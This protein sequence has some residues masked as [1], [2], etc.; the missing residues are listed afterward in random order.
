MQ[1]THNSAPKIRFMKPKPGQSTWIISASLNDPYGRH[2]AARTKKVNGCST[3]QAV[4][5]GVRTSPAVVGRNRK[6]AVGS[7]PGAGRGGGSLPGRYRSSTGRRI[8]CRERGF[9]FTAVTVF[10]PDH[11]HTCIAFT[12]RCRPDRQCPSGYAS[13]P[14]VRRH[15]V[16]WQRAGASTLNP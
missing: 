3:S 13:V 6:F 7:V 16:C 10:Q 9:W 14:L 15:Q 8:R 4:V 11:D 1:I 12:R 2:A 5:E